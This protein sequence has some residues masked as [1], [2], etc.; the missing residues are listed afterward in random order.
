MVNN[1][2]ITPFVA[3]WID[4][5]TAREALPLLHLVDH[6]VSLVISVQT[7]FEFVIIRGENHAQPTN[8]VRLLIRTSDLIIDLLS[9]QSFVLLRIFRLMEDASTDH[10]SIFEL[11]VKFNDFSL[12]NLVLLIQLIGSEY[13]VVNL[14][15]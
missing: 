6:L 12:H 13:Q 1:T 8:I 14:L 2:V 9:P 11:L 5:C 15:L 3:R 7:L 4:A 10:D